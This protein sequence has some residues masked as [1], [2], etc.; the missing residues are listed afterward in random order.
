MWETEGMTEINQKIAVAGAR[1]GILLLA[2]L[3]LVACGGATQE[4]DSTP[5]ADARE[6]PSPS[7][8]LTTTADVE[9]TGFQCEIDRESFAPELASDWRDYTLNTLNGRRRPTL[10][11]GMA[12]LAE[13][14]EATDDLQ[15]VDLGAG[16]GNDT[17]FL[18]AA[19]HRVHSVEPDPFAVAV[20]EECA[21]QQGTS[22]RLEVQQATFET[23]ELPERAFDFA[24]AS[25]SLPFAAPATFDRVWDEIADSLVAGGVFSGDFFGPEHQWADNPDMTIL[26]EDQV[27]A[28]FSRHPFE[29]LELDERKRET[30]LANGG[31]AMFHTYSVIAARLE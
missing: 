24:N 5:A 20:I 12:A 16:A 31:T 8:E 10:V 22:E 18:L 28:L 11:K 29:I 27:R 9:D 3:L 25:L 17:R 26:N 14:R 1:R 15:A 2:L 13:R 4:T 19:G 23:M 7:G 6:Q 30:N 21:R